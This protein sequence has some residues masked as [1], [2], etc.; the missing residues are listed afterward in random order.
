VFVSGLVL[1]AGS[2]VVLTAVA[3][4]RR[5]VH[6]SAWLLRRTAAAIDEARRAGRIRT[7]L[8]DTP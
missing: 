5:R 4:L 3:R 6:Q 8:A 1:L 7:E 2:V